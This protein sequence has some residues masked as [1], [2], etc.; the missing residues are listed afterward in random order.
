MKRLNSIT[1]AFKEALSGAA[2]WKG[3]SCVTTLLLLFNG[4]MVVVVVIAIIM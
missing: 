3:G 4:L 2:P 1:E